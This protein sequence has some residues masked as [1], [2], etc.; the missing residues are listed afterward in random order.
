MNKERS[1]PMKGLT[2]V[3]DNE[4]RFTIP[5]DFRRLTGIGPKSVV[6]SYIDS[7]NRIIIQLHDSACSICGELVHLSNLGKV[8]D[9]NKRICKKCLL[10]L[11]T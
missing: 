2:R 10:E 9:D 11:T 8:L 3:I 4:G 5:S 1:H 6:E 7:E